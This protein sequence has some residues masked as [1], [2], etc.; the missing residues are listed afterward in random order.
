MLAI[1]EDVTAKSVS[2]HTTD[3]VLG[4][5][6][7]DFTLQEHSASHTAGKE[8]GS[9]LVSMQPDVIHYHSEPRLKIRGVKDDRRWVV[10][11]K[12]LLA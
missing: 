5:G 3:L 2:E 7:G 11:R 10:P 6:A 9:F 8:G 4:V 12:K 1:D